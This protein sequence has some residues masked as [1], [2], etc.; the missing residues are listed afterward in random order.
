MPAH[1][2]TSLELQGVFGAFT[3]LGVRKGCTRADVILDL[4]GTH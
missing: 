4:E 3:T 2:I 1:H